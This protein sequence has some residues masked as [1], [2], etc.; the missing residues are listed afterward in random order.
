MQDNDFHTVRGYQLLLKDDKLLTPAMEDYLEMVYR[1]IQEEG[2]MRINTLSE[3]L[4]VKPSSATKMVQKLTELELLDYKKYGIIFLTERGKKYGRFLLK[5]HNTIEKFLRC[6]GT[7]NNLLTETELIEHHISSNTLKNIE[8][9]TKFFDA[10]PEI[11]IEF[12]KF[13]KEYS[14]AG[15]SILP[16]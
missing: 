16:E 12:E 3:M 7:R 15:D 9:L 5:R 4:N 1:N 14:S 6:I 8:L 10:Y 13:K 11:I 2:Y